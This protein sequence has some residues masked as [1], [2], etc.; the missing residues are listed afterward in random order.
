MSKSLPRFGSW[1]G[2]AQT[3]SAG[4]AI[5]VGIPPYRGR[6]NVS[7]FLYAI[8]GGN[9][10][11]WDRPITKVTRC[12]ILSGSTAH[13]W[14]FLRPKG[15]TYIAEAV[16]ANDT[17]VVMYDNP[18]LYATTYRYPLPPG[19]AVGNVAD[20]TP[21]AN[22]YCAFQLDDGSWHFSLIS[23]LSTLTLTIATATPNITGGG[24][25]IGR[26]LFFFGA[27][28]DKDPATGLIDPCIIPNVSAYTAFASED[29]VVAGLHPGDPLLL[30]NANASNASTL[31]DL[32][33]VYDDY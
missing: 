11:W 32:C 13:T 8:N 27:G 22:D 10:N 9:P 33:G 1:A 4:T 23:S 29:G 31:C 15:F 26:V 30:V 5:Y 20:N 25:A 3:Q 16:T 6:G 24:S 21:A 7:P 19:E 18:G 12:G 2:A 17:T 28:A 14:Y